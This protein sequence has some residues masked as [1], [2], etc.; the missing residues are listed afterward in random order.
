M[1]TCKGCTPFPSL[2]LVED[3][4][5]GLLLSCQLCTELSDGK[6]D[7]TSESFTEMYKYGY[8]EN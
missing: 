3:Q 7:R 5:L 8:V 2:V 1:E 4:L 6:D